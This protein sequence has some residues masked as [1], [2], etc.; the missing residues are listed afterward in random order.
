MADSITTDAELLDTGLIFEDLKHRL[1]PGEWID[2]IDAAGPWVI[3]HEQ[4]WEEI[5]RN[6]AARATPLAESDITNTAPL[7]PIALHYVL[8]LAYRT[9]GEMAEAKEFYR[10]Y[11]E[12]INEI[13]PIASGT[14][15]TAV[16]W[17]GGITMYRG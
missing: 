2:K 16:G 13:I 17:G 1:T 14:T 4:A 9:A 6:Y 10:R 7:K 8:Y 12:L 15:G 3:W 5:L 11:N